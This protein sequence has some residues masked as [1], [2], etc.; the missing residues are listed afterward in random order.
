MK[1]ICLYCL[2]AFLISCNKQHCPDG[3]N[4]LPM[5]GQVPKCPEQIE[6]DNDFL[7]ECD[8]LFENRKEAAVRHIDY[9]WGYFYKNQLDLAM[10]RFNQAWLL[11]KSNA[12]IF[13]GYG[14]ILGKKGDF[15]KSIVYLKESISINPKNPKSWE[16]I[17]TSYGQLFFKTKNIE[18]L[19][20]TIESLK[21]SMKLDPK[22]TRVYGE[23]ANV[24]SYLAQ[25]DSLRKY[26]ELSDSIGSTSVSP[27]ARERLK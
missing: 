27:I 20:K 8:E 7:K 23:L 14:N 13:W 21:T 15:E 22:N 2:I 24:Y 18:D 6:I 9:G 16:S 10:S 1:K 26:V 4:K 17:S 19:D 11:D 3:I 5:Y 12:D 25:K